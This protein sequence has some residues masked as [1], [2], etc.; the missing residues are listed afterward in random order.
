M[1]IT[2]SPYTQSLYQIRRK[3]IHL[4][5]FVKGTGCPAREKNLF[6]YFIYIYILFTYFIYEFRQ[7]G[8]WT[9]ETEKKAGIF[10]IFSR[11]LCFHREKGILISL[12]HLQYSTELWIRF[13]ERM[14]LTQ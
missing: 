7:R 9:F 10:L 8:T 12:H 11:E 4:F 14:D 2:P 3:K 1:F 13:L 5:F 6:K